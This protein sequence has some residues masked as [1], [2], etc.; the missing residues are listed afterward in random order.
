MNGEKCSEKRVEQNTPV[1][2]SI[3]YNKPR[4]TQCERT[5]W[6]GTEQYKTAN[7]E[8]VREQGTAVDLK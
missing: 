1:N 2:N 7:R 6:N 4:R 3:D 8:K 5:E